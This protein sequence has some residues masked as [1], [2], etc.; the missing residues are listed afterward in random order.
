[1]DGIQVIIRRKGPDGQ[2]LEIITRIWR[3]PEA[4]AKRPG[5]YWATILPGKP[6]E[7]PIPTEGDELEIEGALYRF[8]EPIPDDPT[9]PR[10][11]S[12]RIIGA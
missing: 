1:M 4:E 3:L 11:Q 12:I 8:K 2:V 7:F 5:E 6:S 9:M 10:G